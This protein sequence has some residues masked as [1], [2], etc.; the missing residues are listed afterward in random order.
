M[1]PQEPESESFER[2]L[3]QKASRTPTFI[4]APASICG[5]TRKN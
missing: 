3:G 5:L 2:I 1:F 4:V